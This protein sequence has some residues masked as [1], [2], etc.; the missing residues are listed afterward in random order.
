VLFAQTL[1]TLAVQL[2]EAGQVG[3]AV[4][5]ALEAIHAFRQATGTDAVDVAAQLRQ[6]SAELV[7]ADRPGEAAQATQ[8]ALDVLHE[9]TPPATEESGYQWMLAFVWFDQFRLLR[10][11]GRTEEAATAAIGAI[12]AFR[13][14]AA[15]GTDAVDV[16]AQL[17]QLSA[18]LVTADRPGE[19]AQATQAALEIQAH[20]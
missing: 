10:T 17:R 5:V 2:I 15:T 6:L 12:H 20:H 9:Y 1:H 4:S 7:A 14:A 18:E 3:Q 11:A 13:Q 16:A 8:A 19:A